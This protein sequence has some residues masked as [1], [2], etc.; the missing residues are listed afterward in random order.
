MSERS[1]LPIYAWSELGVWN[2]YFLSKLILAWMGALDLKIL[3]NLLFLGF[4]LLPLRWR[5]A[6]VARTLIAIPLGIA[7]YYQDTWWPP[8]NRLLAQPGVLDFSWTYMVELVGRFIN[9]P[10]VMVLSLLLLIYWLARPWIRFTTLS[11]T[12]MLLAGMLAMPWPAGLIVGQGGPVAAAVQPADGTAP[13]TGP[14]D[15]ATLDAYLAGF[16]QQQAGLQT[17]FPAPASAPPFDVL[18]LNICSLAWSDLDEVGMRRNRLFDGMDVVFDNFNSA[19]AYS[20]PAAIRLLR[21]SCGQTSHVQLFDPVPAQCHL[22]QNLERLGFESQLA[23]NHDGHFDD[24]MGDLS[25]YGGLAARAMEIESLPRAFEAF[26]RSPLRRDGDVLS[27]WWNQRLASPA[28]QVALFYNTISLHDGNRIIGADGRPAASGFK[29][30]ASMVLEDLAVFMDTLEKSGRRMMVVVVPEHGAALHGDRMQIPG[31]REI[32]SWSITHVPVGVKWIGM[33]MPSIGGPRHVVE[34]SSYLAI[35]EL[36]ART[37][38]LNARE[39]A[40]QPADWEQLLPGLPVTPQ[41]SENEGA[42]VVDYGGRDWL[43]LQGG[44]WAPYPEDRR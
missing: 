44:A 14:V 12:G 7:L 40:P 28:S 15:G 31:M 21:A 25:R 43:R 16:F 9:V 34:P 26:D 38:A 35:S 11:V 4:L 37:Y 36:V 2:L 10:M 29:A 23:M 39:T 3:P 13:V 30:R 6:K 19:T 42:Q 22:M 18:V 8:F 32:P 1:R 33:G 17:R 5:W 20:G 41:V 27:R 24:F